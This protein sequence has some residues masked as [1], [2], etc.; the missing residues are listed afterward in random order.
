[1]PIVSGA[2]NCG[3]GCQAMTVFSGGGG[4]PVVIAAAAFPRDASHH[5]YSFSRSALPPLLLQR[6][7]CYIDSSPN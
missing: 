3:R 2:S 4:G 7:H 1:M 6:L 5:V